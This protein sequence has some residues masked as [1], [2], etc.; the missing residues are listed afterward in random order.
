MAI[1]LGRERSFFLLRVESP[2]RFG[3]RVFIGVT[4]TR[5]GDRGGVGAVGGSV[6]VRRGQRGS[7]DDRKN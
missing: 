5:E 3:W 2:E 6:A 1:A 4:T 7:H